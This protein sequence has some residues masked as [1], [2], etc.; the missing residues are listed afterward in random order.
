MSEN[1]LN[2]LSPVP[3]IVPAYEA[4]E[5]LLVLLRALSGEKRL[6]PIIVVN[7]GSG[8]ASMPVFADVHAIKGVVL[9]KH[10][11]NLGKGA[12]LKT[13]FRYC[14]AHF[15]D[16]I[17]V[18]TADCDG[19]HAPEDIL[20]T[21]KALETHPD[22]LVLG[23]RNFAAS[24]IPARS[25][26]GNRISRMAFRLAGVRVSDTQ[27]GLRGIPRGLLPSLLEI[28]YDRYEFETD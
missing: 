11:R 12:A 9:L 18:V 10:P 19:Q 21:G 7:D 25:R 16:C 13:A 4:D 20:A 14:L 8:P 17:G 23:T 27:T 3:A 28:P 6:S 5:H 2:D 24:D 15:P 22:C 1:L 26:L